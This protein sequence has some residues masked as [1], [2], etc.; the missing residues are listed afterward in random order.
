MDDFGLFEQND[1]E[2][3]PLTTTQ[4]TLMTTLAGLSQNGS[5]TSGRPC[6]NVIVLDGHLYIC[7]EKVN[8]LLMIASL[9]FI[10]FIMFSVIG[11]LTV[12][13][14]ILKEKR[15]RTPSSYL[16]LSLGEFFIVCLETDVGR[17]SAKDTFHEI[18]H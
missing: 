6:E 11:N 13:L 14:A 8:F 18:S 17:F 2:S 4:P 9:F 1:T 10:L 5:S 7:F 3:E 16:I 12:I 15:L